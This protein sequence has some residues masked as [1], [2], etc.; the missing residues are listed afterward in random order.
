MTPASHPTTGLDDTVHQRHRLGILVIT[1]KA[2]QADFGYLREALG[3]TSGNLS[4]HLTVLEEAGLIRVEKGYE[5]KRPRTWV[6][7]T[8]E[9]RDALAAEMAALTELVRDHEENHQGDRP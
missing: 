1:S 5:G 7:I 8:K 6:S 2:R 9:G 3:L 4:A